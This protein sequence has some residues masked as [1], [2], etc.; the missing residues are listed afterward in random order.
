MAI[1]DEINKIAPLTGLPVP[2]T[3]WVKDLIDNK[4]GQ[5]TERIKRSPVGFNFEREPFDPSSYYK[6]LGSY[7]D[8]S[9]GATNVVN[10]EVANRE[11]AE[12]QRRYAQDQKRMQGRL[13]G[14]DPR[15]TY[16]NYKANTSGSKRYRLGGVSSNVA[17]AADYFG[18]R[19]NIK[20]IGGR[21]PGSVPGSDHPHGR[22]LDYMTTNVSKGTALAND[23]IKNYKAWNV[24]YVIWYKHI[25]Q[26]GR[27]WSKYSGPSD[28][29]NHVHVSFYK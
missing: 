3:S 28:H 19:Y 21:G 10:Q 5:Q 25:W 14:V 13:G 23:V 26:P 22:A 17:K 8:I 29:T 11:E 27:G 18:N 7:K 16:S 1:I 6:A 20:T 15:F 24:K 9:R 2:E 4:F 12:A